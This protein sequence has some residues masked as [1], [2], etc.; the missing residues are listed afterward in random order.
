MGAHQPSE[1]GLKA[2]GLWLGVPTLRLGEEATVTPRGLLTRPRPGLPS[3]PS[4]VS[5]AWERRPEDAH[6]DPAGS[7]QGSGRGRG[8]KRGPG[9]RAV[10]LLDVFPHLGTVIADYQQ[11]QGMVHETVLQSRERPRSRT[12]A[13]RPG[14][15][16]SP[17]AC[18]TRFLATLS[19]GVPYPKGGRAAGPSDSWRHCPLPHLLTPTHLSPWCHLDRSAT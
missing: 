9:S 10:H 11:L 18:V 13:L 19:F 2:T 16:P 7:S 14:R 15:P 1:P 3:S 5:G 12:R 17:L 6:H 4:P 8:A